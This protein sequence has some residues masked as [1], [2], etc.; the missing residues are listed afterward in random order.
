MGSSFGSTTFGGTSGGR[1]NS[2]AVYPE[3]VP[4]PSGWRPKGRSGLLAPAGPSDGH[5]CRDRPEGCRTSAEGGCEMRLRGL[6]SAQKGVAGPD[7]GMDIAQSW[8]LRA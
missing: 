7:E 3:V 1:Q 8:R 5:I 2:P 4:A 6:V